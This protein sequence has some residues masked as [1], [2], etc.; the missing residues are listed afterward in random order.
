MQQRIVFC[1]FNLHP[2][3]IADHNTHFTFC[4]SAEPVF[5]SVLGVTYSHIFDFLIY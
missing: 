3:F 2:V 4:Q 5:I 1:V